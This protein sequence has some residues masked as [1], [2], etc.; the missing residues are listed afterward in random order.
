MKEKLKMTSEER[1]GM[2]RD[3]EVPRLLYKMGMPTM[4]GMFVTGL[5]S[6][7]DACFVGGLGTQ[8]MGAISIV[9]PLSQVL[10]GL[11]LLFGGGASSYISRLLGAGDRRMAS[12]VAST[13]LYSCLAIGAITLAA[14]ELFLSGLLSTLGATDT[15][16]PY[17]TE[18]ARVFALSAPL[19]IAATTLNNIL[20]SEGA[21]RLSMSAML[22]GAAVH[23][24]LDPVL[25]Y[26]AGMGIV[27]SAI[28]TVASQA[29]VLAIYLS[30]ILRGR[31]AFSF[32]PREFLPSGKVFGQIFKVGVPN[33]VFQLFTSLAMWLT[34]TAARPYGDEAIAA[35]G[36]V[37]RVMAMGT[38]AVFGFMKGFQ[39][40]A[41]Y[42]YGAGRFDR[43]WE[44]VKVA[45]LWSTLF[46]ACATAVFVAFPGAI[47]SLFSSDPG[48]VAMASSALRANSALFV[49]FGIGAEY[50][51][52]YLALGRSLGGLILSIGRQG[53]FFVPAVLI[54]PMVFGFNGVVFAQPVAVT[55]TLVT[56]V[57]LA[58]RINRE[59]RS[60]VAARA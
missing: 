25:I 2:L 9:F 31:S 48:V 36:I 11:G 47:V 17:A 4:I 33:L 42:S 6:I 49:F 39:P 8:Q 28:S 22:L 3:M 45:A 56:I 18:Y 60:E 27:G 14:I 40:V 26:A 7:V 16:M 55:V 37:T 15:I 43:L 41:G 30:Y 35:M 32:A 51:L 59:I 24:A 57:I 12:R 29:M 46:C 50:A 44:A 34:A 19:T 5:Y 52:L 1:M 10:S 21:A 13:A 54:L 58:G 53:L 20:T 23:V 38:L